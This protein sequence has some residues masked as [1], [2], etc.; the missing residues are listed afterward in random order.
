MSN[1]AEI[2]DKYRLPRSARRL[3][4]S[5]VERFELA[6]VPM[7]LNRQASDLE[8]SFSQVILS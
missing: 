3:T 2:G 5:V 1:L 8:V 7:M 4:A 6:L